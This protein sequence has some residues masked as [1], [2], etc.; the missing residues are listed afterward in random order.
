MQTTQ[1]SSFV[2]VPR[3]GHSPPNRDPGPAQ[4]EE[5]KKVSLS[6]EFQ[7]LQ[8]QLDIYVQKVEEVANKGK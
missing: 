8:E 2:S 7:K 5:I 4:V 1:R 6:V 3:F